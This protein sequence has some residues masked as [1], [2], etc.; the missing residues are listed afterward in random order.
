MKNLLG[1]DKVR[2]FQRVLRDSFHDLKIESGFYMVSFLK[3][4]TAVLVHGGRAG[5]FGLL[6]KA[7]GP[8][9]RA[10]QGFYLENMPDPGPDFEWPRMLLILGP[11][12][13]G[14]TF[15]YQMLSRAVPC[16]V[17]TNF[18]AVCP[19]TASA[20]LLKKDWLGNG[21]A[22]IRNFYGHTAALQDTNEGTW[23]MK[24]L[25]KGDPDSAELRR[26]FSRFLVGMRVPKGMPLVL[27]S[28][29]VF[30]KAA[31]LSRAVPELSFL[32]LK[33]D[34][35]SMAASSYGAYRELGYF[36]P[37]PEGLCGVRVEDP[38]AYAV[39]Q[40]LGIEKRLD[41]EKEKIE[42]SKWHEGCY[43]S[44]C[45]N[46]RAE[47]ERIAVSCLGVQAT[48]LRWDRIQEATAGST[49][50]KVTKTQLEK[51]TAMIHEQRGS[52]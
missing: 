32:R 47:I 14:S 39:R 31:E 3:R 21:M 10:A 1:L 22:D 5:W 33:R 35:R 28:L 27:K 52:R 6:W 23:L 13:S 19:K 12:R 37:L 36:Y 20:V 24:A 11:P 26:R 46:P 4:F 8:L 49:K 44:L 45:E 43:E 2:H 42:A 30:D 40:I 17:L 38:L 50:A 25:F 41:H 34:L 7:L 18:H 51:I 16:M 48:A 15:V 29:S 9:G